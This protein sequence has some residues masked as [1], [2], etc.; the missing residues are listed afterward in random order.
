MKK[1][2]L[3]TI[4][5]GLSLL[6]SIISAQTHF[7][8]TQNKAVFS[9]G[10]SGE[11]DDGAVWIPAV[12]K[13]GDTL[14]MW[15]TGYD[16]NVW[17]SPDAGIGYAWSLDGIKWNRYEGNPVI[18]S[19]YAWEL[20]KVSF[21]T[22]IQDAD[23]FKMWYGAAAP[24]GSAPT[25]VGYATS[26]D[27][28]N[29]TKHA[30]P[31]LECGPEYDWD[32]ALICPTAVSKE[33]EEYKMWYYGGHPGFPL[34][35]AMPQ[36]G[37]AT[38]PDGIEWTKYNDE[39]TVDTPYVAS[40]P[41]IKVGDEGDWDSHRILGTMVL[42]TETGYQAWYQGLKAPINTGT[43]LQIGHASSED[44]IDW[45]KWP[46]NPVFRDDEAIVSWGREYYP[47]TMLYFEGYYHMWFSCFHTN[48][49]AQPKIGYATS[50]YILVDPPIGTIT[51]ET[52]AT[53]TLN[54]DDHFQYIQGLP[55]SIVIADTIS[56]SLI[57]NSDP[58][59]A[60]VNLTDNI[61]E[62]VAGEAEGSTRFEIMAS[63][64]FTK[65]Y[66][67]VKVEIQPLNIHTRAD[68]TDIKIFPNPAIDHLTVE[69]PQGIIHS[70]IQLFDIT[71]KLL[72]TETSDREAH[73]V[74]LSSFTNGLYFIRISNG[75][76]TVTEK[77]IK[78]KKKKA[79]E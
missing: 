9:W 40:D 22:V 53:Y 44:G 13:D 73:T 61:V 35:S 27:A 56:Y 79:H 1:F 4:S 11:W 59:I 30:D 70:Q 10:E 64:G 78:K 5:F 67:R 12:I 54:L 23:T 18:V 42:K 34:E 50:N 20:D 8:E 68:D 24:P 25:I 16:A 58:E 75:D 33:G 26:M 76:Y 21:C 6:V 52:G 17:S 55:D 36:T 66:R 69:F 45:T 74:N 48:A 28:K 46:D 29:W 2:K 63:A 32:D 14:R 72:L 49:S 47:G 15:Y 3:F 51:I 31:V 39:A 77:V 41:V 7:Q 65:N 19:E 37:L 57:S 60:D 71:G 62:I 38:S 43:L